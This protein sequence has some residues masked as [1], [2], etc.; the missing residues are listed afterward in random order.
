M[1]PKG[2]IVAVYAFFSLSMVYP[3]TTV[4]EQKCEM[5]LPD[6]TQGASVGDQILL[7]SAASFFDHILKKDD[8]M[9]K[10]NDLRTVNPETGPPIHANLTIY[11][12][13]F[14]STQKI[15]S[16]TWRAHFKAYASNPTGLI[17]HLCEISSPFTFFIQS[18]TP[19]PFWKEGEAIQFGIRVGILFF[20]DEA[21]IAE[22]YDVVFH[23]QDGTGKGNTVEG[24]M[25]RDGKILK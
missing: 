6:A 20:Y 19:S 8:V 21:Q 23:T 11:T 7:R 25:L 17:P 2:I 12:R 3:L 9:F 15:T 4:G 14:R 10:Y 24:I 5:V 18:T 1:T 16:G 13:E 22:V